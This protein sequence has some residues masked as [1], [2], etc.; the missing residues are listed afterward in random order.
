MTTENLIIYFRNI[1]KDKSKSEIE[2][3]N[4][5]K[6]LKKLLEEGK[7]ERRKKHN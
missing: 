4:A 7:N 6:K 1:L 2:K 3:D 5:R